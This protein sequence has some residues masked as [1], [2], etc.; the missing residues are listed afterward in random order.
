MRNIKRLLE[1]GKQAPWE[2]GPRGPAAEAAPRTVGSGAETG[3]WGGGITRVGAPSALGRRGP[4]LRAQG[5]GMTDCGPH[6]S[7]SP[8][9]PPPGRQA[10]CP[11][12]GPLQ[13]EEH[14]TKPKLS[15]GERDNSQ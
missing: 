13:D 5:S 10:G 6:P 9:P 3:D 7:P 14:L 8:L 12:L 2:T 15:P 11:Q 4:G 1:V